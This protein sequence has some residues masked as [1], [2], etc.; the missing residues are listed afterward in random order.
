MGNP[1]KEEKESRYHYLR[2]HAVFAAATLAVDRSHDI[3]RT[4]GQKKIKFC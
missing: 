1:R 3:Q 2:A 4:I